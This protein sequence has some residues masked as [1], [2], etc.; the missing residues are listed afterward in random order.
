MAKSDSAGKASFPCQISETHRLACPPKEIPLS[1]RGVGQRKS[2][3][4]G[5]LETSRHSYSTEPIVY[6]EQAMNKRGLRWKFGTYSP[7]CS[8]P[9]R[10]KHGK[11]ARALLA[12]VGHPLARTL[13]SATLLSA[14]HYSLTVISAA[15]QRDMRPTSM[16]R[17]AASPLKGIVSLQGRK[18]SQQA[19]AKMAASVKMRYL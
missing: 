18:R 12:E 1:K 7:L 16:S 14:H 13:D 10:H 3:P 11:S 8:L 6:V 2:I 5:F 15:R 17:L 4:G 9:A 19:W